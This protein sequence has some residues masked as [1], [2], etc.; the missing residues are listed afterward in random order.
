MADSSSKMVVPSAEDKAAK[1]RLAEAQKTYGRGKANNVKSARDKKLRSTLQRQEQKHK[2]AVLQAQDAE[3]LLEHTEGFLEPEGELERTY[4][5]RQDEIKS[6]IGIETAKKG[7]ELKLTDMGPY[8]MD[9][10][11]NGR[12]L[13]LAGRKGHVATMDWREGKLG[14][15][16]QLNETVRD[17][18]W[19]HNN[20]FFAVAQKKHT[21]IYDHQGTE[22]HCLSK[23]LEPLFLE[24]LPYHFLLASAVSFLDF[25]KF[26]TKLI[27]SFI[28]NERS[29]QI[30]RYLDRPNCC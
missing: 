1:L 20:Q 3:I 21:Y 27:D 18:R 24:F 23:H 13:L 5:V 16:L 29:P 11:R 28:A 25:W 12:D 6:S 8:R 4:K 22:I 15:E 9:Y 19:L 17:A 2:Q 30:H 10:S 14:C 26:C 7:F